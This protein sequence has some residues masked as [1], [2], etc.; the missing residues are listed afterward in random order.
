MLDLQSI[1]YQK[2]FYEHKIQIDNNE[3]SPI[4][5][6]GSMVDNCW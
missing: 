1:F 2:L 5:R 3:F 4:L 6:L